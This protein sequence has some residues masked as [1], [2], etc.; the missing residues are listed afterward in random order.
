M[1]GSGGISLR[2]TDSDPIAG[3]TTTCKRVPNA[4]NVDDSRLPRSR[5]VSDIWISLTGCARRSS[6]DK[7]K[8][9]TT[10]WASVDRARLPTSL[11]KQPPFACSQSLIPASGITC[12]QTVSSGSEQR[13]T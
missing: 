1:A 13:V 3:E 10:T 4:L 8:A 11:Q 6:C 12:L 9:D 5:A 2:E 7:R